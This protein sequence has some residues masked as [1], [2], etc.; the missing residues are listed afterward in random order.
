MSQAL[1]KTRENDPTSCFSK[2]FAEYPNIYFFNL[3]DMKLEWEIL[4]G[5]Q[6]ISIDKDGVLYCNKDG[7]IE[8]TLWKMPHFLVDR[9][10]QPPYLPTL[11]SFTC[12]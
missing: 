10:G 4:G 6:F 12:A 1:D 5:K 8:Q 3:S 11:K 9:K 2:D 7:S